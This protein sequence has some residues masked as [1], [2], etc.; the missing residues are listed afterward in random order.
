M[1]ISI[2]LIPLLILSCTKKPEVKPPRDLSGIQIIR[3][4]KTIEIFK[5]GNLVGEFTPKNTDSASLTTLYF[6]NA[7]L[8]ESQ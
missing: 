8:K 1:K 2:I 4:G 6:I 7:L 5:N 3:N